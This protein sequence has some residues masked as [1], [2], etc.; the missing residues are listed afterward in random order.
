MPILSCI[1]HCRDTLNPS[2]PGV[3]RA[4]DQNQAISGQARGAIA[5]SHPLPR[6][7]SWQD[8]KENIYMKR[9]GCRISG[10][11]PATPGC[12]LFLPL[13]SFI[14]VIPPFYCK[15]VV[16]RCF[17]RLGILAPSLFPAPR[18]GFLPLLSLRAG[19]FRLPCYLRVKYKAQNKS[20]TWLIFT[21]S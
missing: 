13:S 1:I 12:E 16:P 19:K 21:L 18:E 6:A 20:T 9:I 14:P 3:A 4:C 11:L 10:P 8:G 5:F 2:H 17:D 15:G 7:V